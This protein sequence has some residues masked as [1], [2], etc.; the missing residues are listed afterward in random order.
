MLGIVQITF[1]DATPEESNLVADLVFG[2]TNGEGRRVAAAILGV[3]DSEKL[4]PLFRQ[5]WRAAGNWRQTELLVVDG[6]PVGMLQSGSSSMKI[7]PGV[8]VAAIR[9]LGLKA[10]RMPARLRITDR[11]SPKKPERAYIVSEVHVAPEFRGKGLGRVLMERAE[12]RAR[13][14][15]YKV[16]ALHTRTNNPARHLYER[17]GYELAGEATDE[18]HER[19][20]GVPGNV[21]YVK[22]LE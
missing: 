5:V 21:L 10:L 8:V 11:V 20:T 13:A 3:D 16:M 17:C 2:E 18:E 22:H 6:L 15:G 4:R 12:E 1:R 19:L 14:A 9:A 7:T